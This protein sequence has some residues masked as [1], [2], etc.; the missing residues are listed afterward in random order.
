MREKGR[1][2]GQSRNP[3]IL[4]KNK[5][6]E[7]TRYF[8]M[9]G[10]AWMPACAGMTNYD[11]VFLRKRA[12]MREKLGFSCLFFSDDITSARTPPRHSG[13]QG[14]M[15]ARRKMPNERRD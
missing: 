11:T 14:S 2:S 7:S 12:G 4:K 9:A 6:S 13:G 15:K 3:E 5:F 1:H 8:S 10:P